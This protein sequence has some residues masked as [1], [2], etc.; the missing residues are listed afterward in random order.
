M[1]RPLLFLLALAALA[2]PATGA[3]KGP[4]QATITGPG[5]DTPLSISGTEG[6]GDLGLLV[7][8][9]GFFPAAFPQSP[10]PMLAKQP[11]A[12][13]GPRY[14]IVYR[15][16]G[17]NSQADTLRQDLYPYAPGGPI[18][19]MKP[20]QRFWDQE[21]TRGGWYRGTV[22]LRQML[23]RAGLPARAASV[24]ASQGRS[25]SWTSRPTSIA[26][27]VG[28]GLAAALALGVVTIRR[29]RS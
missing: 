15:L 5:L 23:V 22:G 6:S 14:A 17:P 13:L 28:V 1:K 19:Y 25:K 12:R 11:L 9:A 20:G 7:N 10:D 21:R 26:A 29:R 2:L 27:A 18:S 4:D 8:E 16:P 24:D 3:A